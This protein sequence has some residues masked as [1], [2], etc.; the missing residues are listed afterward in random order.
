MVKKIRIAYLIDTISSDRAG[1]EKQLLNIIKQLD[2]NSFEVTLICLYASPWMSR[3]RLPCEV[4]T[5]GY[6]G[7]L[8]PNFPLVVRR[9][10]H[11]LRERQ[12]DMV[13][14]FFEDSMFVG[15]L[16]KIMSRKHHALVASRRDLG[17]GSDEP[18]YHW[19]FKKLRFLIF[20][21]S[22]GIA[23][24]AHAIKTYLSGHE[25]TPSEKIT[26]IG[27]GIYMP[28]PFSAPPALFGKYNNDIWI[29]IAANLKPVKRIDVF[30]RALAHLKESQLIARVHAVV[31]GEGRLRTDLLQLATDLGIADR[32]HFVGA[33]DN[34]NDYLQCINIGVLCSD[35]EGLPNAIMEYMACG[36]PV[37]AT[38]VGGVGEL[39]DDTNGISVPAGDYVALGK[40]LAKLVSS[41]SLRKEMGTNSLDKIRKR[42]TWDIIMPQWEIYYRSI[43]RKEASSC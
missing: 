9:Y 34:V 25:K 31:L 21:C 17:L 6:K 26:V 18:A 16:G 33:I 2:R 36:L 41:A 39:V 38:D 35:K 3:N 37:V 32:V 13:Q 30:L 5:I 7:F 15:G 12:I 28:E 22:D 24:N 4:T 40:A 43:V 29:G 10:L 42:S 8:K 14:T 19:L 20:R 11:I 27:N 23:V 1:T